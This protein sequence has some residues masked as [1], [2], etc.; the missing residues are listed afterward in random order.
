[1]D[2]ALRSGMVEEKTWTDVKTSNDKRQGQWKDPEQST[3]Y[4]VEGSGQ[5]TPNALAKL[6]FAR[7]TMQQFCK[8]AGITSHHRL[9]DLRFGIA[10]SLL[11]S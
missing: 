11:P 3:F 5:P 6:S 7:S 2:H 10:A 9:Y 1:M 8:V 4:C